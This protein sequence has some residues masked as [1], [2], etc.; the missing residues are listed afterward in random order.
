MKMFCYRVLH[1]CALGFVT[2][3]LNYLPWR[4]GGKEEGVGRECALS[5]ARLLVLLIFILFYHPFQLLFLV[6]CGQQVIP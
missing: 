6:M 1:H 5:P 4:E 3:L 2:P